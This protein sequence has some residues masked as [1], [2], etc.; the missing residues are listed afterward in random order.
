MY[1]NTSLLHGKNTAQYAD[2]ATLV[3]VFQS[4]AF[5][6]QTMEDLERVFSH[7]KPGFAYS[8]IGNP[9]V[10]AFEQRISELEGGIGAVATS[11]GMAA[12]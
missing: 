10:A 5:C 8:R 12:V 4:N 9:T 3:P 1:F 7:K 2:G 11:S 6:C